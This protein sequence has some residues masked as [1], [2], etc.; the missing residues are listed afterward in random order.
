MGYRYDNYDDR[1]DDDYD[2]PHIKFSNPGSAL[3]ASSHTNPRNC[4]CP[5]CEREN[6]LTPQ[7]V[8]LGY[9][10]DRCAD[11]QERGGW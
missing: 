5:S 3:R 6:V 4:A 9:Q 11:A 2:F 7:D 1:G 10:C 8:R